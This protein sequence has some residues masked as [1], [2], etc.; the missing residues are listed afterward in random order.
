MRRVGFL[1]GTFRIRRRII[2]GAIYVSHCN[3]KLKRGLKAWVLNIEYV[4]TKKCVYR[5]RKRLSG[6]NI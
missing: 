6:I 3:S 2:R 4:L 1:K 5:I